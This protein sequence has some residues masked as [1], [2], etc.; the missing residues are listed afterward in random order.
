MIARVWDGSTRS[1]DAETYWQ[2]LQETGV[3][4]CRK[5]PG[6]VGVQVLRRIEGG[7][8]QFRFISLWD[9]LESIR[10]FA[11]EDLEKAVYF[12]KDRQYLLALDPKVRHYEVLGDAVLAAH[13]AGGGC[14]V[15]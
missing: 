5:T 4:E 13:A 9:S 3:R 15:P 8:A 7:E 11:G 6:N 1:E 12:P 2:Y 14:A 10:A